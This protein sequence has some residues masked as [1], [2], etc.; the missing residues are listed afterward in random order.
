MAQRLVH[1]VSVGPI[2]PLGTAIVPHGLCDESGP[3]VPTQIIPD[4]A[5]S[6]A[7]MNVTETNVFFANLSD[8]PAEAVFRIERDHSIHSG[9]EDSLLWRGHVT[10]T[11][12]PPSGPASGDLDG[13]YPGPTVVGLQN[14]PIADTT[15]TTDEWLRF[16]GTEWEP[17]PLPPVPYARPYGSFSDSSDQPFV[18][19]SPLVVKFDTTEYSDGISVTNDPIT[20]RPTRLTVALEGIYQFELSPQLL[21]TGGGTEI[22]TFWPAINGVAVP[23]S[24]SS[25]EMGNNNNRTLPFFILLTP[26]TAGQY[27]EW[28]FTSTTGT[29][30]SLEHFP[31][32]GAVPA[33]P[34]VI[35]NVTRVA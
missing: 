19:G 4:R 35:A 3:L 13:N 30:L 25:L 23:R 11:S 28:L 17:T 7:V 2:A 12:L 8:A 6:I 15:P 32:A 9:A 18:V 14:T 10:P 24:A 29:N 20:G 33:I 1:V 5:T 26:M 34:S 21:H 31:A 22:V 16:N 27:V